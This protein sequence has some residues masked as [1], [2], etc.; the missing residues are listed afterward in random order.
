MEADKSFLHHCDVV[1]TNWGLRLPG[2]GFDIDSKLSTTLLMVKHVHNAGQSSESNFHLV[3]DFRAMDGV[4]IDITL[5]VWS[6]THCGWLNFRGVPI[7]VVFVEGPVHEFKYPRNSDFLYELWRKILWPRISNP[8]NVWFLFNPRKLVPTNI[9]PSTVHSAGQHCNNDFSL[10]TVRLTY[11]AMNGVDINRPSIHHVTP[12]FKHVLV[13]EPSTIY[14]MLLLISS[15]TWPWMVLTLTGHPSIML[16]LCSNT[17]WLMNLVR[18]I[19]CC[20]WYHHLPGHEWCWYLQAIHPSRYPCVQTHTGW[21]SYDIFHVATDIITYLAM[22]G[23][24]IDRPAIHHV[25]PVV[26]HVHSAGRGS[27]D[28]FHLVVNGICVNHCHWE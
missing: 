14:S 23:V 5:P 21:C 22:D 6:N 1:I 24:D 25:T 17:Y 13:D 18:Y 4:V 15:L 2:H 20:Y 11:L 3:I 16:P 12:V 7:F 19:P 27:D 9:K 26:E 10:I 8:M 28:D